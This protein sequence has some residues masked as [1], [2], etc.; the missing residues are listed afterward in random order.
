MKRPLAIIIAV[1]AVVLGGAS[2]AVATTARAPTP[3]PVIKVNLHQAYTRALPNIGHGPIRYGVRPKGAKASDGPASCA[4]PNCAVP[5]NGGSVEHTPKVYVLLWG[6]NWANTGADFA[7]LY[8]LYTGLGVTPQDSWSTITSQY[9]DG[10]GFPTF[11][12]SV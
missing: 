12:G 3:P 4:E 2:S 9:G 10:S 11:S 6:P 7:T 1:L 5:W 8:Y